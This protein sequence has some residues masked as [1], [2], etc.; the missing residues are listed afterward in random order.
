M[1]HLKEVDNSQKVAFAKSFER[2]RGD[3]SKITDGSVRNMNSLIREMRGEI[4]TRMRDFLPNDPK[5]PFDVRILPQLQREIDNAIQTFQIRSGQK[6][7][8]SLGDVFDLGGTVTA[9][10]LRAASIPVTF[11]SPTSDILSSASALTGNVITEA[12]NRLGNR[13]AERLR[14]SSV[15]LVAG[16]KAITEIANIIAGSEE[17]ARGLRRRTGF[18][19]Q[20][21]AIVRTEIGAVY[22]NAQQSSSEQI[23]ESIPD[24]RKRW[25]TSLGRRSGHRDAEARYSE[26]GEIGPILIKDSFRVTDFSRT[27][28]ST[29][30]TF[31]TR[32]GAQR[33]VKTKSFQR[34]G[35]PITDSMLFPRDPSASAGNRINCSCIILDVLPDSEEVTDRVLGIV[36]RGQMEA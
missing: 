8:E 3:L 11:P 36:Q 24:L 30:A 22:S 26:D 2:A 27:G 21:E 34:R 35:R 25:V 6:M 29:F 33:V 14:L 17:V 7:G 23:V 13:V 28:T 31:R 19:F 18:E 16:S 12:G 32:T 1:V 10:A 20:A 5:A 9:N 4:R 15:G